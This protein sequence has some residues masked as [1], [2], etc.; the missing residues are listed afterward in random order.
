MK[1]SSA[2][3]C[4]WVLVLVLCSACGGR[5]EDA[6]PACPDVDGTPGSGRL[7]TPAA[8]CVTRSLSCGVAC[9][10][11]GC[12]VASDAEI[13]CSSNFLSEDWLEVAPS[14]S[15]TYVGISQIGWARPFAVESN[16]IQEI[17]GLSFGAGVSPLLVSVGADGGAHWARDHH[18][19]GDS[20]LAE[21]VV[22]VYPS[23]AGWQTEFIGPVGI[24][25][26]IW[27]VT[28]LE[29]GPDSTV[30][31][32][33]QLER[34]RSQDPEYALAERTTMGGWELSHQTTKSEMDADLRFTVD[35]LGRPVT[36]Q[37]SNDT[38][39]VT[40]GGS[41]SI[42]ATEILGGSTG[43]APAHGVPHSLDASA[44]SYAFAVMRERGLAVVWRDGS[45]F[46]EVAIPETAVVPV[47]C[48]D[49]VVATNGVCPNDCIERQRGIL[50]PNW[51]ASP[52]SQFGLARADDG[53]LWLAY[54]ATELDRTMSYSRF[55]TEAC[56]NSC[57]TAIREERSRSDLRVVH[58][59]FDGSPPEEVMRL[60]LGQ[61]S[62]GAVEDPFVSVRAFGT[63]V[64]IGVHGLELIGPGADIG[65]HAAPH[66]R[67][68]TLDV[69]A[70]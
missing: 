63:R 5:A 8:G 10:T 24:D 44:P 31:A 40:H 55:C 46:R 54:I 64:A 69:K 15:V 50:P 14:A 27:R 30:R 67:V 19:S 57:V 41:T 23:G 38:V 66:A 29:F 26:P 3:P 48:P 53:T 18:P 7:G 1:R 56:G 58:V 13:A 35:T 70:R 60:P 61:F 2:S 62:D 47:S 6:V 22:H 12:R 36:F 4:S 37:A 16:R 68:I 20:A 42:A 33:V 39:E 65:D 34:L 9:V 52:N 51:S 43:Y 11:D 17:E 21:G 28:S 49:W 25:R 45:A 32:W 59:R